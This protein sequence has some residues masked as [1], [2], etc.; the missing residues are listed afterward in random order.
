MLS[1]MRPGSVLVDVAIDQGGCFETSHATTHDDPV[2]EVDAIV[3]YCVANMPGAVPITSTKGLTNV[4]LPYVEA[5]ANKGLSQAI[6][7]DPSLAKG[8]NTMAGKLTYQAVAEAHGMA[9]TALA[10]AERALV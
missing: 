3:H 4:T 7:D 9:F 1:L 10:D 5:I 6:V 2:F 8:V